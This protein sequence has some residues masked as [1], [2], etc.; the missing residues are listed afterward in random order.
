MC[1]IT[2][3]F[4]FDPQ[5]SV[6]E[7]LLTNMRQVAA[8]RGPDDHGLHISHN[9]GL[10]FNRLSI[11]D[12]SGGHQPM[13][14]EDGTAWIVFNGEIYNFAELRAELIQAGHRFRTRSDTETVL[15]AWEQYGKR[16]VNR[17]RGMFA[18]VIWDSRR[19]VLFGARDRMG[20]KPFYYHV[21]A[22]LFAFASEIKSLLT[23]PRIAHNVDDSALAD[24]LCHG[25]SL[26]PNTLF[27]DIEKLPPAHSILVQQSGITVERYWE[28]PMESPRTVKERDALDELDALL[29]DTVRM[30][31]ISDVPLGV[32]LS[33]G[34][35][36]S[37]L[38][39]V[40]SRLGIQ[41]LQTFSVGY[42]A[43]ESELEY[44]RL[45]AS[46]CGTN[47]H[48]FVLTPSRFR[49]LLSKIVWHMDEPVADAPSI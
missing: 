44:A 12:I 47:H 38:V 33:G 30:H 39:S 1:G 8:H 49:D 21:D 16:C 24:Y 35:D 23:I 43:P 41:D 17:L 19:R 5:C 7:Q 48:E 14:N 28:I 2:G 13:A 46:H 11:I 40:M 15:V 6:D 4:Y 36:S 25:Y 42:D 10:G 3:L 31:L 45:V 18:F 34:L 22:E 20:I 37:S 27:R 26:I 9:V 32:F 29:T